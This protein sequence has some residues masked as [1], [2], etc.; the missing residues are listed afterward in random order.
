[1]VFLRHLLNV[2]RLLWDDGLTHLGRIQFPLSAQAVPAFLFGLYSS[3]SRT[4]IHPWCIAAG[5]LV[6]T[7]YVFVFYFAYLKVADAP[8]AINAGITGFFL[9][10]AVA[11]VSELCRRLVGGDQNVDQED[12]MYL[13]TSIKKKKNDAYSKDSE[14][15]VDS[16]SV[17]KS[18]KKTADVDVEP[19][20]GYEEVVDH[21]NL[22]YPGRP[23]WDIPKLGRFG[24]HALTPKLIC[25]SMEGINE[26][27]AN[28]WWVCLMLFAISICTP[29]TDELSPPLDTSENA[30]SFFVY[31]PSV[32]N[33]L[34]WWAFKCILLCIVPTVLLLAA[35]EKMPDEFPIDEKKI[36]QE[37]I[38]PDLV[39]MTREELGR[40][41]SYDERN[42]L[43]HRR[44]STISQEMDKLGLTESK[45][46]LLEMQY[47]ASPSQRHLVQLAMKS[48]RSLIN[49]APS[50]PEEV[51][52]AVDPERPL[53]VEES[54]QPTLSTRER[55]G[56]DAEGLASRPATRPSRL[57]S[58]G[59]S[60]SLTQVNT[61]DS[62]EEAC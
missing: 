29:L 2:Y 61:V 24:D 54:A 53:S 46:R 60:G 58:D 47:R 16:T 28:P 8:L 39:E 4:D 62:T 21:K 7:V 6:A 40:R 43:I 52:D 22:L 12:L 57:P 33:G 42:I 36:E 44:R 19:D 30:D 26:P 20:Y 25:E 55:R 13:S 11:I 59:L 15:E 41:T 23:K 56:D 18:A 10:I 27:M 5:A 45:R 49:V 38:N 17:I 35:I 9:Q 37:G 50:I 1:M 32:V 14:E 34:P 31:P 3:S 48:S 51:N